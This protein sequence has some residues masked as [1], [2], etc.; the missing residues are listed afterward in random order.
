MIRHGA[1]WTV[2][3]PDQFPASQGSF[4]GVRNEVSKQRRGVGRHPWAPLGP[5]LHTAPDDGSG[6]GSALPLHT[7]TQCSARPAGFGTDQTGRTGQ[8]LYCYTKY[9]GWGPT[10]ELHTD[11]ERADVEQGS[12]VPLFSTPLKVLMNHFAIIYT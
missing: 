3:S 7:V 11:T 6:S 9:L 1:A 12:L 2:P 5:S 8:V 4:R 10:R